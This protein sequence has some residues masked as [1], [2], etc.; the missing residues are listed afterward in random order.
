MHSLVSGEPLRRG[1]LRMLLL[2][3]FA[4]ALLG[5]SLHLEISLV[6]VAVRVPQEMVLKA[7]A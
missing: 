2:K 6:V 4:D 7:E 3:L 5:M 1:A